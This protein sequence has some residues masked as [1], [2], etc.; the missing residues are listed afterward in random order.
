MRLSKMRRREGRP[1]V[2]ARVEDE[3]EGW[4]RVALP[5]RQLCPG[6][7]GSEVSVDQTDLHLQAA[8]SALLRP[9]RDNQQ[10]CASW[11]TMSLAP[12][13]WAETGVSG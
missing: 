7:L 5:C 10:G 8:G 1:L 13:V 4:Q 11:V 6:P 3:A 12:E 9:R 2:Q